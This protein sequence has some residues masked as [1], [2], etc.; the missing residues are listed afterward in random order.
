VGTARYNSGATSQGKPTSHEKVD[1][2]RSLLTSRFQ[3]KL[4]RETRQKRIY[5]L[6][7]AKAGPRLQATAKR[8]RGY[9]GPLAQLLGTSLGHSV[10]GKTGV[11]G[12][13]DHI[14]GPA[15]N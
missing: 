9:I 13:F 8:D 1:V 2:L 5:S 14:Q 7:L 10:T 4:Q 12:G 6:T 11:T 3:L 15:A